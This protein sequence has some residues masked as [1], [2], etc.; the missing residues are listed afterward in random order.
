MP[1]TLKDMSGE[2]SFEDSV[3]DD[4]EP[5]QYKNV[6]GCPSTRDVG[7]PHVI[8]IQHYEQGLAFVPDEQLTVMDAIATWLYHQDPKLL[9]KVFD[10]EVADFTTRIEW[11]TKHSRRNGVS[12]I[13]ITRSENFITVSD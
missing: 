9:A 12:E 7:H 5:I 10:T 4:M 8:D 2:T 1:K 11:T 6:R 13:T 3:E